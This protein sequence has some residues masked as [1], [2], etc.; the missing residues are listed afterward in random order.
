M[1]TD[2]D[3]CVGALALTLGKV[4]E[5]VAISSMGIF[6]LCNSVLI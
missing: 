2:Y 6:L 3:T 5:P 1:C 4:I